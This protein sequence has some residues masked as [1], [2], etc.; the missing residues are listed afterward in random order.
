MS[1]YATNV[2][3][4][5]LYH[6]FFRILLLLVSVAAHRMW[7]N[8]GEL[9]AEKLL[10]EKRGTLRVFSCI[11]RNT[12]GQSR[13][14]SNYREECT[15]GSLYARKVT[16]LKKNEKKTYKGDLIH[17]IGMQLV[18]VRNPPATFISN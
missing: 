10:G 9:A 17:G 12:Y 2:L 13:A 14:T 3:A 5:R 4:L 15:E 16:C 7:N 8:K 18:Q 6:H 1:V 11:P